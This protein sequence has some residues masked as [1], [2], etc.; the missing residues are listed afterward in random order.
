V[1]SDVKLI[2][3]M[4]LK[5]PDTPLSSIHSTS[6]ASYYSGTSNDTLMSWLT[7][8]TNAISNAEK[9]DETAQRVIYH[10]KQW[11]DELHQTVKELFL[12]AIEKRS[13]FTFD[14][15]HW[16]VHITKLLL[17]VSKADACNDH[18]RDELRRSALWLISVL[19]WVPDEQDAVI[20]VENYQMTE[21]LFEVAID[22][23]QRGCDDIAIEVRDLLISWAFKAGKYQTGR[24]ILERACYGLACLNL[25][26]EFDD[27]VLLKV[28][29]ER[30]GQDGAP[31]LEL[32]S[33]ASKN[34]KE[35]AATYHHDRHV[36]R[37]IESAMSQVDQDKLRTLLIGIAD[38]LTPGIVSE[39]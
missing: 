17:A 24:G 38:Q 33:R 37:A 8:L 21:S 11:A 35:K 14:I 13:G 3:N 2:A 34:I 19:S 15:I 27:A 22:A 25:V 23:K 1:Q 30:V 12:L 9:D 4:Y 10:I 36:L 20:F 39:D 26:F 31:S 16:I 28:I 5:I 6:L 32:R 29:E 7:D 18:N